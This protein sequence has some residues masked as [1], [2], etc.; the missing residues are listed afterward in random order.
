MALSLFMQQCCA[1]DY[2]NHN[3][4]HITR[5]LADGLSSSKGPITRTS[6][7]TDR[8]QQKLHRLFDRLVRI[9]QHIIYKHKA[10][11]EAYEVFLF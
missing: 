11:W 9:I 1:I 5:T 4:D 3:L 7:E 10:Q 8:T 2:I 6:S